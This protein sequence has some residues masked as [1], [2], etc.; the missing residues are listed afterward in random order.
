MNT[1]DLKFLNFLLPILSNKYPGH[2][3]LNSIARRYFKEKNIKYTELE[4]KTFIRNYEYKYFEPRGTTGNIVI[5]PD[6][7]EIIDIHGSLSKYLESIQNKEKNKN[8]WKAIRQYVIPLL[9]LIASIY[10]GIS[11]ENKKEKIKEL[12]SDIKNFKIEIISKDSIINDLNKKIN[13]TDT[14]KIN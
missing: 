8:T 7:K 13:K 3:S 10:F 11:N 5:L 4:L 6:C 2:L 9:M 12:N 14:L 1:K